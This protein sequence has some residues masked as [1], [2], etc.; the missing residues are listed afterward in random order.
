MAIQIPIPLRDLENLCKKYHIR[1]LS[2]FGSVLRNDFTADSDIDVL[3]EFLPGHTPGFEFFRI[4]EE[5]SRA[6]N[7]KVDLQTKAFLSR[8]FR[9]TID[10]VPLVNTDEE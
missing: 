9:D 2:L 6:F 10:P 1:Q 7:R 3:V 4:E 5:L 8:Y